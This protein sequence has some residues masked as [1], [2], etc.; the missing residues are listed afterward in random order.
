MYSG[1]RFHTALCLKSWPIPLSVCIIVLFPDAL[2]NYA[3]ARYCVHRVR[4]IHYFTVVLYPSSPVEEYHFFPSKDIKM[5][6]IYYSYSF[7]YWKRSS[8]SLLKEKYCFFTSRPYF[9]DEIQRSTHLWRF[10][11]ILLHIGESRI[12]WYEA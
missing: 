5:S 6:F 4:H 1:W 9:C 8:P 10:G 11:V 12:L 2:F 3:F 7:F